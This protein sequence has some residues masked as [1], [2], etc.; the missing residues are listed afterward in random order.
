MKLLNYA[1]LLTFL[2]ILAAHV[3]SAIGEVQANQGGANN[4]QDVQRAL[5]RLSSDL[6]DLNSIANNMTITDSTLLQF[7][8]TTAAPSTAPL[9]AIAADEYSPD[10]IAY[11]KQLSAQEQALSESTVKTSALRGAAKPKKATPAPTTYAPT[12]YGKRVGSQIPCTNIGTVYFDDY[13][14]KLQETAAANYYK[15]NGNTIMHNGKPIEVVYLLVWLRNPLTTPYNQNS[16]G[17]T[18]VPKGSELHIKYL[19]AK[20]PKKKG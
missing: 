4:E 19:D 6:A 11:L 18:I 12:G 1:Q 14:L 2:N 5:R 3:T 16:L 13:S 15:R 20:R 10:L 9:H 8:N 7:S 17:S